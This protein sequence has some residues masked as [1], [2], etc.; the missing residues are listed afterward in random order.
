ML[1]QLELNPSREQAL[2]HLEQET[3]ENRS[4]LLLKMFDFYMANHHQPRPV[5]S[6]SSERTKL[7]EQIAQSQDFADENSIYQRYF[8]NNTPEIDR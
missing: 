6:L 5:P 3:G 8:I 4:D 2:I 7:F 1:A